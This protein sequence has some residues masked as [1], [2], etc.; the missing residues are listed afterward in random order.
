M[1]GMSQSEVSE[2]LKGCRVQAYDVLGRICAGLK[3][4]RKMMGLA[5]SDGQ[6]HV[7]VSPTCR[8]RS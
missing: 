2:V 1:V 7:M 3:V 4:P 6:R 8:G 5:Y